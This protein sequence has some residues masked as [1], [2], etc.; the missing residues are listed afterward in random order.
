ALA[1]ST[2]FAPAR[3]VSAPRSSRTKAPRS[4]TSS[5]PAPLWRIQPVGRAIDRAI[6]CA[7]DP[8]WHLGPEPKGICQLCSWTGVGGSLLS[9]PLCLQPYRGD[10]FRKHDSTCRHVCLRAQFRDLRPRARKLVL[11]LSAAFA[12][13]AGEDSHSSVL[14]DPFRLAPC[15]VCLGLY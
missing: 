14:A 15:G 6:S 7:R 2:R 10:L 13:A 12:G 8:L 9:C 4:K 3:P 1:R 5:W 11:N